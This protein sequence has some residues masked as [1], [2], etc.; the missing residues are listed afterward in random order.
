[1]TAQITDKLNIS[2]L[3]IALAMPAPKLDIK[4]AHPHDQVVK[5]LLKKI[6]QTVGDVNDLQPT[7]LTSVDARN[8]QFATNIGPAKNT[9]LLEQI[10]MTPQ[11][12]MNSLS[13]YSQV[14]SGDSLSLSHIRYDGPKY[15]GI[16]PSE[17]QK[18][19]VRQKDHLKRITENTKR[20]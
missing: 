6:S 3:Q 17:Y 2:L 20:L 4:V 7:D 12:S 16:S 9:T 14:N 1:M 8:L 5:P 15:H 11:S 10:G 13:G 19:M 18:V